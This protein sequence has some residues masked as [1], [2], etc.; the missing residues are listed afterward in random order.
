MKQIPNSKQLHKKPNRLGF[1]LHGYWYELEDYIAIPFI[2]NPVPGNGN[3]ERFMRSMEKKNKPIFIPTVVTGRLIDVLLKNGY[4]YAVTRAD[5]EMF[6]DK[7][8]GLYKES[9]VKV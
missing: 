6:G 8:Q 2:M 1:G 5:D 9:H 7:I 4:D 3:F